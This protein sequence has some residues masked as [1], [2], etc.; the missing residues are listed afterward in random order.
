MATPTI[1]PEVFAR[2][3]PIGAPS[4][5]EVNSL[6]AT[7]DR[8][9]QPGLFVEDLVADLVEGAETLS[10]YAPAFRSELAAAVMG[11][12]YL[13]SAASWD[14]EDF[15]KELLSVLYQREVDSTFDI[16][17]F[18]ENV[19]ILL[20]IQS[21]RTSV[22]SY[23]LSAEVEQA[24]LS[25]RIVTDIRPVFG[26]E[27]LQPLLGC[28]VLHSIKTIIKSNNEQRS[29]FISADTSDLISLREEID[30]AIRK[31]EVLTNL[32]QNLP[33]TPLG[34]ITE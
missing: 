23:T 3:L 2:L 10:G 28:V 13:Y 22:K 33:N 5:S 25:A 6:A 24:F 21:L 4:A 15:L 8:A 11:L 18:L 32:I 14:R 12:H 30:R 27:L 26:E 29:L 1:P 20:N 19:N 16:E 34:K 31:A 17:R 9:I 7:L